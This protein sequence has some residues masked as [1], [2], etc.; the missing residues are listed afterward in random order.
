MNFART[1]GTIYSLSLCFVVTHSQLQISSATK[2]L[3]SPESKRRTRA[4]I[5]AKISPVATRSND[6]SSL[7]NAPLQQ[8]RVMAGL[9]QKDTSPLFLT[10][11]SNVLL[12]SVEKTHTPSSPFL[13]IEGRILVPMDTRTETPQVP[14]LT[15]P[16]DIRIMGPTAP[17]GT[18]TVFQ[19][20]GPV[21]RLRWSLTLITVLV[22]TRHDDEA[23]PPPKYC[24]IMAEMMAGRLRPSDN[25]VLPPI[26]RPI[27]RS[28]MAQMIA[29]A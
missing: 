12:T 8:K 19:A 17:A 2:P 16:V 27:N 13:Q 29:T 9:R 4:L 21:P 11:Q 5:A 15:V 25:L 22:D 23:Q 10:P 6:T 26:M 1:H 14:G 3:T 20:W 7:N 24:A 18:S 28:Q